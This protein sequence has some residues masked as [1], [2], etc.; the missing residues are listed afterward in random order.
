M[1][2]YGYAGCILHINLTE[3]AIYKKP[4]DM[5]LAT[6]FIGG[7]GIS[8]Q[9]AYDLI[10]PEVD[11]LSPENVL[12]YGTSPLTGTNMPGF[13]RAGIVSK[14][15]LTGLFAESHTGNSIGPMLKYAGY[16]HLVITGRASRPVYIVIDDNQVQLRD[17]SSIWGLNVFETSTAI[18][19]ELGTDFWISCIGPA[20]ERLVRFACIVENNHG[21]LG[22]TGLG[23]VAGSKN[24]KAVAVRGTKGI[25]VAKRASFRKLS[26]RIRREISKSPLIDL[27]R[28]GGQVIDAYMKPFYQRGIYTK[29]NFAEGDPEI[30]TKIFTSQEFTRR[31][32]KNYYA[33]FGCPCGCKAIIG[34]DNEKHP[35]PNFK[36][37][38]PWGTP[39]LFLE[40]GIETWDDAVNAAYLTNKYGLDAFETIRII[41]LAIEL[42]HRGIIIKEETGGFQLDWNNSTVLYLLEKMAYK[43]GIGSVLAEGVINISRMMGE[44]IEEYAIHIKGLSPTM[45]LRS[46]KTPDDRQ[47]Y[48]F[49]ENF[50]QLVD[51]RGAHHGRSWSITY[52]PRDISSIRRYANAI[53]VPKRVID[54]I[55][56]GSQWNMPRLLKWVNDF[57]TLAFSLGL[58]MR[59]QMM[60]NYDLNTLTK[61]YS[62]TTGIE[63]NPEILLQA[64]E[65]IWNIQRLFNVREGASRKDDRAPIRM[66]AKPLIVGNKI[67]PPLNE[68]YIAQLMD[69]YYGESGW[70]VVT[71]IPTKDRLTE[72]GLVDS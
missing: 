5:D 62:I 37:S 33:C 39:M 49:L 56:V 41:S 4:L 43:D 19:N 10:K 46:C 1:S 35:V 50:G 40:C 53:G 61:L 65:R 60:A 58:C 63:L 70:D 38:N 12:V 30:G 71:G 54:S 55:I 21:M 36:M 44:N 28:N 51:P 16:D 17:A 68:S 29:H 25:S 67:N 13:S 18:R 15:P 48:L 34:S 57:D 24:L 31:I 52:V 64:G 22:R 3:R 66:T 47:P 6:K 11:P 9:L 27:W 7:Q 72:L 20:G 14:S 23:A 59:P 8:S 26:E 45:D 42:F 2:Y 32:W 69:E